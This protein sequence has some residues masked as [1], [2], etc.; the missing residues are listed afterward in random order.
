MQCIT[1]PESRKT[2]RSGARISPT[3]GVGATVSDKGEGSNYF[4][5]VSLYNKTFFNCIEPKLYDI[6]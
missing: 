1:V 4:D 5:Y 3:Q 6:D 2:D